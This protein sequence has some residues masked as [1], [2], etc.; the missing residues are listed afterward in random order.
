MF[1]TFLSNLLI[2]TLRQEQLLE[3]PRIVVIFIN[4]YS[5]LQIRLSEIFECPLI[6]QEQ[7]EVCINELVLIYPPEVLM[8]YSK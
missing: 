8:I 7:N 5:H 2:K 4:E 3:N 6:M 1:F